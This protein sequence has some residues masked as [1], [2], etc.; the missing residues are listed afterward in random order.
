[1]YFIR[2]NN[3]FLTLKAPITTTADDTF[4]FYFYVLKKIKLDVSCESS[5]RQRINMKYQ[6]LFS[7]KNNE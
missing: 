4:V 3:S 1:M 2:N 7:L 5:A 6:V